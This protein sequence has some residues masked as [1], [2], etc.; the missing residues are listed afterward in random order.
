M[1]RNEKAKQ[2]NVASSGKQQQMCACSG[3]CVYGESKGWAVLASPG[4]K[5]EALRAAGA[6]AAAGSENRAP[7]Q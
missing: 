5:A 4:N 6:A 7:Q 1:Q 3:Y 2:G